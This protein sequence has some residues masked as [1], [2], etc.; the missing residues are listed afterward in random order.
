M[1]I[2]F[3]ESGPTGTPG[4]RRVGVFVRVA[5]NAVVSIRIAAATLILFGWWAAY[6][7]LG[8]QCRLENPRRLLALRHA[9]RSHVVPSR[10]IGDAGV[11]NRSRA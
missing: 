6:F 3:T 2:E 8:A 9:D 1:A 11:C 10:R 5:G 4:R 7:E